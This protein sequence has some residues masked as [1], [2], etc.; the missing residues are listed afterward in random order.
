MLRYLIHLACVS[1]DARLIL[2][3][4]HAAFPLA[5]QARVQGVLPFI[6]VKL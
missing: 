4:V 2:A 5:K 1:V 3:A 6:A